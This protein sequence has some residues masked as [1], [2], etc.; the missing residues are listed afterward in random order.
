MVCKKKPGLTR[1]GMDEVGKAA[2]AAGEFVSENAKLAMDSGKNLGARGARE[3]VGVQ[4]KLFKGALDVFDMVHKQAGKTME[5]AL[6]DSEYVPEEARA[7]AKEWSRVVK[8]GRAE[9]KTAVDKSFDLVEQYLKRIEKPAKAAAAKPASKK[10]AAAK[11]P[12]SA[13]PAPKK[14]AAVKKPAAR[15]AAAKKEDAAKN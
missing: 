13:K 12:A 11:K 15:K 6:G 14:K 2:H 8:I 10:K 4:R 5:K 9:L 7:V 3:A 1:K